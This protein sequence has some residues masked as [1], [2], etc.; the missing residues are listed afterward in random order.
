MRCG[1]AA[2]P[3]TNCPISLPRVFGPDDFVP[4]RTAG[5]RARFRGWIE[6]KAG[7]WFPSAAHRAGATILAYRSVADVWGGNWIDP[8]AWIPAPLFEQ[9]LEFL[10]RSRRTIA[11]SDL[12]DALSSGRALE[13]G[14]VVLTF[15]D[16]YRDHLAVAQ[17][18]L[19]Q[20]GLP[21]TFFIAPTL[22]GQRAPWG[23]ELYSCIRHR[24]MAR[25]DLGDWGRFDLRWPGE[26]RKA[27]VAVAARLM[28]MDEPEERDQVIDRVRQ[29]LETYG[30]PPRRTMTWDEVRAVASKPLVT[31]G[32]TVEPHAQRSVDTY[33][34][35]MH[36]ALDALASKLNARPQFIVVSS[37]ANVTNG[38]P[39]SRIG[40]ISQIGE[41]S[42]IGGVDACVVTVRGPHFRVDEQSDSH[43]LPRRE[44]HADIGR[45]ARWTQ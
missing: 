25:L 37:G 21:A 44:A 18:L 13:P 9:H 43:R 26:A 6:G 4:P 40:E 19:Q 15:D 22:V 39:I 17:P 8:R 38:V 31:I 41:I 30:L 12:V 34:A 11:L 28:E 14:T 24:R 5:R 42:K 32:A 23:D 27:F 29:Q 10:S 33:R 2:L 3:P 35:Q 45:L 1:Y 20:Y 16:A 36:S 7:Q